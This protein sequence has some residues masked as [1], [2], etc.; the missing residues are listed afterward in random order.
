MMNHVAIIIV[1]YNQVQ[2]TWEGIASLMGASYR[3][4]DIVVVDNGLNQTDQA[5]FK[6]QC[7][8]SGFTFRIVEGNLPCL[9]FDG[10]IFWHTAEKNLGYGG[11]MNLGARIAGASLPDFLLLL[12]NDIISQVN[13][14]GNLLQAI[15]GVR[16]QSDFGFA[17]CLIHSWPHKE[18]W[19]AGGKLNLTRCMGE[20]LINYPKSSD[21]Q[22]TGFVTGCCM[23]CRPDVYQ[24]L[25]GM[26]ER[27]FL[28][29][30]DVDLCYRA[31][32]KGYKL[33]FVPSAELFHRV[34]SSTGGDEKP[35]SVHYSSRNRILMMRKHFNGLILYRFYTFFFFSRLLKILKWIL[36]GKM[37]LIA[38]LWKGVIE[39]FTAKK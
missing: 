23:L 20:H 8:N 22:E 15:D 9:L 4:F 33:F 39:G 3:K 10:T 26:D 34:G 36:L 16:D 21:I 11:G 19:Y 32:K 31:I 27:F 7:L 25:G 28:Y 6:Q 30:E 18:I 35:L 14:L 24:K 12:N 17:G 29:L 38:F 1:H 2:V 37:N 5:F 13:F